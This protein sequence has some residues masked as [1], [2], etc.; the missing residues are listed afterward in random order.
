MLQGQALCL[1]RESSGYPVQ[2]LED[3]LYLLGLVSN[4]KN[5]IESEK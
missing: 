2:V 3:F 5:F 4:F 1:E